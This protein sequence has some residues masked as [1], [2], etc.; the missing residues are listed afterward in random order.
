VGLYP[1][2][3][4]NPWEVTF[5]GST[6]DLWSVENGTAKARTTPMASSGQRV[7]AGRD[8]ETQ[9]R[10]S[11]SAL[12]RDSAIATGFFARF[13]RVGGPTGDH[14]RMRVRTKA[15]RLLVS[16]SRVVGAV[17]T[18]SGER[19]AGPAVPNVWFWMKF[20]VVGDTIQGK[21]WRNRKVEPNWLATMKHPT[22]GAMVQTDVGI[23][24]THT[25]GPMFPVIAYD[26]FMV[27]A[28]ACAVGSGDSR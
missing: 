8:V 4:A 21:L 10:F 2:V 22:I 11:V 9:A 12:S 14:V 7:P 26:D 6:L 18:S 1:E 20:K 27:S 15:G 24:N 25:S 28:P 23:R 5:G 16:V 19:D 3:G 13:R 17:H